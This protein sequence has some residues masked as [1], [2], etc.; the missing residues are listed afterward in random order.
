MLLSCPSGFEA[1]IPNC[2]TYPKLIPIKK[3]TRE[4]PRETCTKHAKIAIF[5]W[6]EALANYP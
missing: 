6:I 4:R 5:E 1:Y 3:R 2:L